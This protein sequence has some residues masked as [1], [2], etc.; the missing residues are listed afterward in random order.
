[1]LTFAW[2]AKQ[3]MCTY[4]EAIWGFTPTNIK[5]NNARARL[6]TDIER[7]RYGL[8]RSPTRSLGC[9]L[10]ARAAAFP[11]NC[12]IPRAIDTAKRHC[13]QQQRQ[14]HFHHY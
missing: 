4:T 5:V 6:H 2:L 11:R 7:E 3:F 14:R 12:S 9:C 1:V 10:E 8:T 13:W